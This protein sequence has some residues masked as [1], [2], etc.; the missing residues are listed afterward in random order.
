MFCTDTWRAP[1]FR[2]CCHSKTVFART[3]RCVRNCITLSAR[4]Y[5]FL[6]LWRAVSL[7]CSKFRLN[8]SYFG[9]LARYTDHRL[10]QR[11]SSPTN[12]ISCPL[13]LVPFSAAV[14]K[15]KAAFRPLVLLGGLHCSVYRF[16]VYVGLVDEADLREV[17][18]RPLGTAS[19]HASLV[20]SSCARLSLSLSIVWSKLVH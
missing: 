11:E 2:C 8:Y 19:Y 18:E 10:R 13:H 4:A 7:L 16:G 12:T 14:D 17:S 3:R 15:G 5:Y 1:D 20:V 6:L 9:A